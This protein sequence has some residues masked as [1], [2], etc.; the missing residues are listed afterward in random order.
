MT[1]LVNFLVCKQSAV[2]AILVCRFCDQLVEGIYPKTGLV[3][4]VDASAVAIVRHYDKQRLAVTKSTKI[5]GFPK[6]K[7]RVSLKF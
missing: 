2:P 3:I 6:R 5:V 1:E 7:Q 4:L